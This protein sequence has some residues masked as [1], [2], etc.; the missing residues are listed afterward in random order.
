[1][2]IW[3]AC[4]CSAVQPAKTSKDCNP[5]LRNSPLQTKLDRSHR[6]ARENQGSNIQPKYSSCSAMNLVPSWPSLS[7][8]I[9]SG[10]YQGPHP[11]GYGLIQQKAN[12]NK[13]TRVIKIRRTIHAPNTRMNG[14]LRPSPL[15][16]L[17]P[18]SPHGLMGWPGKSHLAIRGSRSWSI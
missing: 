11:P 13:L 5:L 1:M 6:N 10:S 18:D 12:T 2:I 17:G 9:L 15:T 4:Q 16:C 3:K 7:I 14:G 8:P